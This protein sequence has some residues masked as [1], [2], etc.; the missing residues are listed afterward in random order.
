[1]DSE[2][3]QKK[4][5]LSK[6]NNDIEKMVKQYQEEIGQTKEERRK[7]LKQRL[8]MKKQQLHTKR[9]SKFAQINQL[10]KLE[11]KMQK[12]DREVN[13]KKKSLFSKNNIETE[14]CKNDIDNI[15]E[16]I[17]ENE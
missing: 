6:M 11:K 12:Q 3:A 13:I 4:E 15:Y 9:M 10:E 5:R 2:Q 17:L 8:N 1:M 14:D 7:M 16:E